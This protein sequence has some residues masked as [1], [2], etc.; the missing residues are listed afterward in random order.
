MAGDP[1]ILSTMM[2]A[3]Q[4]RP[5]I[6]AWEDFD[7]FKKRLKTM[8]SDIDQLMDDVTGGKFF[9]LQE[10]LGSTR[11]ELGS[12]RKELGST[13]KELG[14]TRKELGSARE[15]LG[16]LKTGSAQTENALTKA[17]LYFHENNKNVEEIAKITSLKG[18]V[19]LKIL[20]DNGLVK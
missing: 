1:D 5:N 4:S 8:G 7:Y 18:S 13:R 17:V 2:F 14:S 9:M 20:E 3:V 6:V 10:E 15:E 12:T 16:R 11:K 19:V